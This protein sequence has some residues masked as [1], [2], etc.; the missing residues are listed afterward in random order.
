MSRRALLNLG[1]LL[2]LAV[3]VLLAVYEPGR[4][5]APEARP[6]TT[7]SATDIERIE[8]LR[9]DKPE[10]RLYREG[11]HWY[12]AGAPPLRAE[13]SQV[14]QLLRLGRET[15][16]RQY[17]AAELDLVRVGLDESASRLRF[18]DRIE[19]RFGATDPLDGHRY[20][21]QGDQVQL[22]RDN[23]RHLVEA[24][25]EHWIDRRLLP[26]DQAIVS[27]D[28]PDLSL[29][30]GADG[31]WQLTPELPEIT[32]DAVIT[33]VDRW[34]HAF[35]QR[36]EQAGEREP[37]IRVQVGLEGRD[38]PVEFQLRQVGDDW[39]FLR[40]D[41]GLEYRVSDYMALQLLQLPAER[42]TTP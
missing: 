32:S 2:A 1:L 10:V 24:P 37:G 34:R 20:V 42:E 41:L 5:P 11:E 27:L 14:R 22:V 31:H 26:E 23:Y 8:L 12:L 36:V 39:R 17:A 25:R 13:A 15:V 7:L 18:N 21:Q 40:T 6:L 33:L 16:L 4:E 9:S 19:L 30:R 29:R 35:A 3:L 28:L 38:L